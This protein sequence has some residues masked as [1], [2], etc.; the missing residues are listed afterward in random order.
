[1]E[2]KAAAQEISGKGMKAGILPSMMTNEEVR[3][4]HRQIKYTLGKLEGGGVE[5]VTI[6]QPDGKI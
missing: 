1:M 5:I 4:Q 6:T 3:Q 2:K